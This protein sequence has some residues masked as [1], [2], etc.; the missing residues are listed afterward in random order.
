MLVGNMKNKPLYHLKEDGESSE[1]VPLLKKGNSSSPT[2]F[3][4]YLFI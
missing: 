1:T 3:V 4:Y 2:K